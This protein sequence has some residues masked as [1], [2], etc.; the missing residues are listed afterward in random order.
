MELLFFFF[1]PLKS[2]VEVSNVLF[3]NMRG[4]SASTEAIKLSCS[5][6]VPCHGIA[7]ENVRLILKGGD[8]AAKSAIENVKWVKAG[9]VAQQPSC[10]IMRQKGDG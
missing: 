8:G 5:T 10:A 7:L 1:F 6:T 3:K 2:A 9:T 4:A